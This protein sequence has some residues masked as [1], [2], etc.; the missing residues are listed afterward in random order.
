MNKY[1]K[2][3]TFTKA[4]QD[5][6]TRPTTR[7]DPDES[8]DEW[9]E[10]DEEGEYDDGEEEGEQGDRGMSTG[11]QVLF[12][13]PQ[14]DEIVG[15]APRLPAAAQPPP[16]LQDVLSQPLM[17][18]LV[19]MSGMADSSI[20]RFLRRDIPDVPFSRAALD[21]LHDAARVA[22]AD[23]ARVAPQSAWDAVIPAAMGVAGATV[24]L[25]RAARRS[26]AMVVVTQAMVHCATESELPRALAEFSIGWPASPDGV[27]ITQALAD[28]LAHV[29]LPSFPSIQLRSCGAL[30]PDPRRLR[31]AVTPD[32]YIV[33][34]WETI[35]NTLR[36]LISLD[37]Q[38]AQVSKST[39]GEM[40]RLS[41]SVTGA[42]DD[43]YD[44]ISDSKQ[45][46]AVTKEGLMRG[47]VTYEKF[48]K[49][50]A[51]VLKRNE[52][53][54]GAHFSDPRLALM[55]SADI[56]LLRNHFRW[57]LRAGPPVRWS[58]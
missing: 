53:M 55:I 17:R 45:V 32:F 40:E 15:P 5:E 1:I 8:V 13:R 58:R 6:L 26:A 36:R 9:E 12:I 44:L 7:D 14:T 37:R 43:A 50:C 28:Y 30:V 20:N 2:G 38:L 52:A 48:A 41:E 29:G 21:A 54:G 49:L 56:S 19:S 23:I 18:F 22:K 16:P 10:D 11:G 27:T 34:P 24:P 4:T 3:S 31:E 33:A 46:A 47:D 35:V 57:K 39:I 25:L 51:R 42:I